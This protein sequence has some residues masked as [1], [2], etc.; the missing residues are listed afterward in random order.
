MITSKLTVKAQTTIPQ[1]V[2]A[3]L[4]LRPGDEIVYTIEKGR[5]VLTKAAR[6]D[7]EDPFASFNEWASEA[8]ERGYAK[9]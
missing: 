8:D 3:A 6:R 4:R 9:L 5:V 7:V 1:P 2:R